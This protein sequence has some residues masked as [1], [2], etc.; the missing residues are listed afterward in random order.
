[1]LAARLF[2][3]ICI[4]TRWTCILVKAAFWTLAVATFAAF[5][6]PLVLITNPA[7]TH[8]QI[9]TELRRPMRKLMFDTR[10][11]C[12]CLFTLRACTRSHPDIG[13][14]ATTRLD[15][16]SL[17]FASAA[18]IPRAGNPFALTRR[19]ATFAFLPWF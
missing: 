18:T 8:L 16:F 1:R 4:R 6:A 12:G 14:S 2:R 5:F 13:I 9:T 3:A 17:V 19:T 10:R 7:R 11:L 15:F